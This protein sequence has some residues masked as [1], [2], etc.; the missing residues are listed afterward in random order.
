MIDEAIVKLYEAV[1]TKGA[2]LYAEEGVSRN[3]GEGWIVVYG[4]WRDVI[5][6]SAFKRTDSSDDMRRM[7]KF[8]VEFRQDT[9]EIKYT[10]VI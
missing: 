6:H 2:K 9:D 1:L 3:S 5:K 10:R 4:T 8:A 7:K